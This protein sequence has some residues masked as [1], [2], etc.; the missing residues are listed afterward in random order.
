MVFQEAL[1]KMHLSLAP[2]HTQR[3]P[4]HGMADQAFQSLPACLR[5]FAASVNMCTLL[6]HSV[7]L[8][9]RAWKRHALKQ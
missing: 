5:P 1:S 7:G 9:W 8:S 4:S 6:L 3:K 2:S